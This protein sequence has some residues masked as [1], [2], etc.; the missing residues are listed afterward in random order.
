MKKRQVTPFVIALFFVI[1]GAKA[2]SYTWITTTTGTWSGTANWSPNTPAGGPTAADNIYLTAPAT[3]TP[4]TLVGGVSVSVNDIVRSGTGSSWIIGGG[5]TVA[6]TLTANSI[7]QTAN[8]STIIRN[9]TAAGLSVNTRNILVSSGTLYFG[10]GSAANTQYLN[11]L[12]VTGTT[13]VSAGGLYLNIDN[14][15]DSY[16]LG[17]L[18][19][20]GG[21]VNLTQGNGATNRQTV[22][23][24][25]GLAGS[26]GV[27]QGYGNHSA[28]SLTNTTTIQ[29]NNSADYVSNAIIRDYQSGGLAGAL[30]IVKSGTGTQSVTGTNTYTGNTTINEGTFKMGNG[31]N[32]G[33]I[34]SNVIMT[35]TNATF[36]IDRANYTSQST[37]GTF[38]NTI[39]GSGRL[40]KTGS[41]VHFLSG[42]NTYTGDTIIENGGLQVFS[43][44]NLGASTSNIV[45]NNGSNTARIET[46]Q[47]ATIARNVI[48]NGTQARFGITGTT[49]ETTFSGV[50]SGAGGMDKRFVGTLI[51]TNA[52]TYQGGTV[53]TTGTLA[54]QNSAGSAT[55]T[56]AVLVSGTSVLAGTGHI[57]PDAGNNITVE[58]YISP[59][60]DS[61]GTLTL[62]LEGA[63]KL[64]FLAGSDLN[65]TLGTDADLVD[66]ATAG[67]WLAGSGNVML[68]LTLGDGFNYDESY[69]IFSD[70]TTA[71]FTLAGIIGY[72]T[73]SYLASFEQIGNNYVVSFDAVPEPS[74]WML[75]GL[76]VGLVL[77]RAQRHKITH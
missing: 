31:G 25:S 29:I 67:D 28:G 52:N 55:G 54:A 42:T 70:V 7:S 73:V 76:G 22:V 38:A 35:S 2:E 9:F 64:E 47:S 10:A 72:D 63:S 6:S 46:A 62:D 33:S 19:T 30:S 23:S 60:L 58:G 43:D 50:I 14:A 36:A 74:T 45:F 8:T 16:S 69:V 53:I 68:N 20:T 15:T 61:T 3:G 75:L 37:S 65:F 1:Q 11:D 27:I 49:N 21:T 77:W 71:A 40:L 44:E 34:A 57:A 48:I 51:L 18:N 39:S 13:T 12:Q 32:T 5:G 66:F 56:G 4:T 24:V 41:G 17:L 26:G 59:G